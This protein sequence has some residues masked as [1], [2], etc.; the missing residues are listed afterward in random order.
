MYV[1]PLFFSSFLPSAVLHK[2][3]IKY[4]GDSKFRTAMLL[5]EWGF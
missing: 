2:S 4:N 1:L 5:I 3:G